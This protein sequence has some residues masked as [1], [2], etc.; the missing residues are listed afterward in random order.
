MERCELARHGPQYSQVFRAGRGAQTCH[1]A[2]AVALGCF[3]TRQPPKLSPR[4]ASP[5]E[6]QHNSELNQIDHV[7]SCSYASIDHT[8]QLGLFYHH[9]SVI[10][11]S[12]F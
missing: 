11:L 2:A 8:T 12:H 6:Y 4:T 9:H 5:E 7:L 10:S 3:E 1:L